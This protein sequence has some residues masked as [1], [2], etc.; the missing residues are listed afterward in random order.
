MTEVRYYRTKLGEEEREKM[1]RSY[2]LF[3]KNLMER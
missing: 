2:G 3:T 1:D